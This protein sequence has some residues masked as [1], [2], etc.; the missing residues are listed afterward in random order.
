MIDRNLERINHILKSISRIKATTDCNEDDF[1]LSEDKIDILQHHIIIIGEAANKIS[2]DFQNN[3]QEIDWSS[4]IG[5]RNI[6]VHNYANVK[7]KMLWL[8]AK[9]DIPILESHLKSILD[10]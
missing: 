6:L 1:Y 9:N 2:N 8:T 4:I 3:H 10:S 7:P 5:M